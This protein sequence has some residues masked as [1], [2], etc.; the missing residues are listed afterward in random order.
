MCLFDFSIKNMPSNKQKCLWLALYFACVE[1]TGLFYYY[2]LFVLFIEYG[3]LSIRQHHLVS[4]SIFS[5]QRHTAHRNLYRSLFQ[6][7]WYINWPNNKQY[8]MS[9]FHLY[10]RK[11]DKKTK[12]YMQFSEMKYVDPYILYKTK[13]KHFSAWKFRFFHYPYA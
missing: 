4:F 6:Y 3:S 1:Y 9:T 2:F 13:K 10:A 7:T 12:I 5:K 8:L 11:I